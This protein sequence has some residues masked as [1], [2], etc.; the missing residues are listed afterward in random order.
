MWNVFDPK[1]AEEAFNYYLAKKIVT[2]QEEENFMIWSKLLN[3]QWSLNL[4]NNQEVSLQIGQMGNGLSLK[5]L[6][7]RGSKLN[8]FKNC[9]GFKEVITNLSNNRQFMST[10][11]EIDMAKLCLDNSPGA[12]IIFEPVF[13]NQ[14]PDFIVKNN[15]DE[16][17]CECKDLVN[18]SRIKS[19][20]TGDLKSYITNK[21]RG[22]NI[23]KDARVEFQFEQVPENLKTTLGDHMQVIAQTLISNSKRNVRVAISYEDKSGEFFV[24]VKNKHD[25]IGYSG[26]NLNMSWSSSGANDPKNHNIILSLKTANFD[27]SMNKKIGEARKQIPVGKKGLIFINPFSPNDPLPIIEKKFLKDEYTHI[28]GI[29]IT[30][31]P[32]QLGNKNQKVSI[33]AYWNNLINGREKIRSVLNL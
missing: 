30:K 12:E 7:N 19:A 33:L 27:K 31:I 5:T 9:R 6:I 24:I 4:N 18:L 29:C 26:F 3:P 22:I 14:N 32:S 16:V 2:K 11:Y 8:L 15:S 10:L 23:P 21:L 1:F 13:K 28:C 17:V 25:L 20:G